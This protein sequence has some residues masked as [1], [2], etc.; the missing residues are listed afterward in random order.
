MNEY[1][2]LDK[3]KEKLLERKDIDECMFNPDDFRETHSQKSQYYFKN[4][5]NNLYDKNDK[6]K[7]VLSDNQARSIRN[8]AVMIFN[9]LGNKVNYNNKDYD[10]EYEKKLS[11]I[12]NNDLEKNKN[13]EPIKSAHL[14]FF[15]KSKDELIFGEAKMLEYLSSPKYLK[16]TYLDKSNY[17]NYEDTKFIEIFKKFIR[18]D[19]EN[20]LYL[21][22]SG[23]KSKYNTYDAF[24]MLLHTLG[25]YRYVRKNKNIKNIKLINV[26]WGDKSIPEYNIEE[27]EAKNFIKEANIIFKDLFLEEGINFE[28]IYY[29]Y[30]DFKKLLKFEDKNREK[31]LEKYNIF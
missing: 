18:K 10:I 27:E 30:F 11:V 2:V 19:S 21:T 6:N 14:D 15:M 20:N 28:I 13:N 24:Q 7:K 25:I 26:V 12:K 9:L 16:V 29:N 17:L 5:D 23:Y 31:Y 8:S 4:Y 1:E 3:L 22:S